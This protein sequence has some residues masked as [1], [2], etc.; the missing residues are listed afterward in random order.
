MSN[1]IVKNLRDCMESREILISEIR[2]L[3]CLKRDEEDKITA[4]CL[5]F[6]DPNL[7]SINYANV[8]RLTS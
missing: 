6:N 4:L 8:K 1:E 5:E 3:N 7:F 2:E